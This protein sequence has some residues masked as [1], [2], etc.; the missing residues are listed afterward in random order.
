MAKLRW[1]SLLFYIVTPRLLY[2]ARFVFYSRRLPR[3]RSPVRFSDKLA[4]RIL[5]NRC[6]PRRQQM[7]DKLVCSRIVAEICPKLRI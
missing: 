4:L 7:S 2:L 1:M 6:S 5:S 3:F